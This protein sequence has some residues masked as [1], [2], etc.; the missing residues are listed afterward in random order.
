MLQAEYARNLHTMDIIRQKNCEILQV[1]A[2][3][4]QSRGVFYKWEVIADG[5]PKQSKG[6]VENDM[7]FSIL[8]AI[9]NMRSPV[10]DSLIL[11]LTRIMGSYGQIWLIVG[12]ALCIFRKTRR[13]G[14]TVLL[15]YVL[16]FLLGQ[17]VL[18]D[19]IARARPCHLD[20]AVQLLVE[21]PSSYSCPSTHTAWAF[22]AATSI[23][24][25]F[26]KSGIC[27]M[28][29]AALIGFSR[30][31]LFVHFPTDVLLGA[32]LGVALAFIAVLLQKVAL[33]QL[34]ARRVR[35]KQ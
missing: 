22:A 11:A 5:R 33:R 14:T 28:I 3:I 1:C 25:Y 31:Y 34:E 27:V 19:W 30:L 17:L 12:V 2:G 18:K 4:V 15:S 21:R 29:F 32:V 10:L 35:R 6:K 24:L 8:Y 9:Q 26:R 20:Q 13:C 16:V 23:L 7:D